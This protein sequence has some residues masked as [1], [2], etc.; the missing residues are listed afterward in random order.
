MSPW[1]NEAVTGPLTTKHRESLENGGDRA[2]AEK[3][4]SQGP[5]WT[6][7][8]WSVFL[9]VKGYVELPGMKRHLRKGAQATQLQGKMQKPSQG[10][11]VG[12]G[13]Q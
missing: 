5:G 10:N 2:A 3:E 12:W 6:P 9:G 7:R 4:R 11:G 8:R 1:S 13:D